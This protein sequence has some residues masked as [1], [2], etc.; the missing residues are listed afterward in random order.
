MI[1]QEKGGESKESAKVCLSKNIVPYDVTPMEP[2]PGFFDKARRA[3]R[4]KI[5][6]VLVLIRKAFELRPVWS[7]VRL[8]QEL[9]DDITS[10]GEFICMHGVIFV[11]IISLLHH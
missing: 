7:L 3:D 1:S 9:S 2:P 8:S 4:K 5:E 6:G 10:L 11:T